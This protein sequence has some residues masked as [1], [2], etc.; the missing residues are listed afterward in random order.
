VLYPPFKDKM[1][2]LGNDLDTDAEDLAA[3]LTVLDLKNAVHV[4]HSTGG[5]VAR[6]IGR[7]GTKRVTKAVKSA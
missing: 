6:H 1:F 4:G 3:L 2:F 7:H 5:E